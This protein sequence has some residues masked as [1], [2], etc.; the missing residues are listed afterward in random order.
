LEKDYTK[1][2]LGSA[3]GSDIFIEEKAYNG[4]RPSSIVTQIW[5]VAQEQID[6][7]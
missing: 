1:D 4:T 2:K 6:F 3:A 5:D 7:I